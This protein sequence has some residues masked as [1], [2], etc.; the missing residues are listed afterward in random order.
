[1]PPIWLLTILTRSGLAG[2]VAKAVAW[3]IVISVAIGLAVAGACLVRDAWRDYTAQAIESHDRD[4]SLDVANRIIEADRAATDNAANA[5][6]I[7]QQNEKE[8][9][10][11]TRV[12]DG[13]A[14]AG[15]LARMRAQQHAGRR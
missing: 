11:A 3:I 14:T 1:M 15:V 6:A 8:L 12:D 7:E 13:A 2:R 9:E 10:D 4:I 5:A